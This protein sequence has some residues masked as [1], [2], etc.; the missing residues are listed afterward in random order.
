V[1]DPSLI[2]L[3]SP[4]L[5]AGQEEAS[6]V[7][8]QLNIGALDADEPAVVTAVR[9]QSARTLET[10]RID[11]GLV[12]EHANGEL[13]IT[14]GGYG[15]RQLF[16]LVQNGADE[17]ANEPGGRLAVVL[18]DDTLYCANEGTPVTVEGANTILRMSVSRKRG[19]QIGRFG[20]GVKSVLSVTDQPQFFSR[21][22]SFGFDRSWSAR[23][24]ADAVGERLPAGTDTPVLRMARPLD[25][26]VE[27]D[28]DSV[29]RELLE[30]ATT[31]VKLPLLPGAADRLGHDISGFRHRDG[32]VVE[33]FPSGFQLFSSH[34]GEVLLEDR[35]QRPVFRRKL[36]VKVSGDKRT[37]R[38]V[39]TGKKESVEE[40]SV[41]TVAHEPTAKARESA[42]ELHDRAIIDVS[43]AV[44][45]Y[46]EKDGLLTVAAG[47]GAFWSFFPTKYPVSLTGYLNA[48]WKTNEDRQNLLDGSPLNRE[49]LQVAARLVVTSLPKLA[50]RQDPAAYLPLLPGRVKEALNWAEAH[51]IDVLWD[52][53]AQLPSLPDQDGV[54]RAPRD[55]RI[56]PDK[57]QP[58]WLRMWSE[59]PKRPR[60]WVHPSVEATPLRHGKMGHILGAANKSSESVR[61]WLEALVADGTPEA[62]C[63]AIRILAAMVE[64][65]GDAATLQ[66][67]RAAR[68]VLTEGHGLVAPVAGK[69]FH[70]TGADE[71]RDD[72]V[73][74]HPAIADRMEMQR[75]LHTIGIR[76]ADAH[77]RFQGVLDQGFD[78]YTPALWTQFWTLLRS[79]GGN[80][81]VDRI[82]A[83]Y[84]DA[85][86]AL[87]VR[88]KDGRFRP[89]SHCLLPGAVVPRDGSRDASLTVDMD[90]HG[91]D[92]AIFRDLGLS[93][94][95]AV[96]SDPKQQPWFS[97]YREAMHEEYLRGLPVNAPRTSIGRMHLE[98]AAPAG[99]LDL[100][101]RL[102]E[103]GRAAFVAA[104]PDVGIVE[105]WT[106]SYGAA[107]NARVGV[108]SPLL[109][110]LRRHGM[111]STSLGIV[112]LRKAVGPQL[113]QF[114]QVL[115][116]ASDLSEEK[117]RRLHLPVT[118]EAVPADRW[119]S[120]LEQVLTSEDDAFIGRAYALL[121]R[122]GFEFPEDVLTRCRVGKRWDSRADAEIAV[123][124]SRSDFDEL[125]REE[126][127]ALLVADKSDLPTA[128]E[129]IE[130]W[131]MSKVADV[132]SKQVRKV[133]AHPATL[134]VDEF[135][136]L[137]RRLG[138]SIENRRVQRCSDLDQEIRTPHA[139]DLRPLKS[140]RTGSTL[141]VLDTL[142]PIEV[143]AAADKE[144]AWNLGAQ[145]CRNILETMEREQ[146]S[147]AIQDRIAEIAGTESVIDKIAL[148]I[149]P[150]EL[151]RGL[152]PGLYDSEVEERGGQ[153]PDA[154]R[155]AELAF[156]A[157]GE[158]ILRE[159]AKALAFA[160]PGLAPSS[161]NGDVKALK[162]VTD[163]GFP[164]SFAGARVPP[165]QSRFTVDGPSEFP[166]LHDYQE[167]LAQALLE[168][169]DSPNPQRGML[170]MPTGAG[171]TRV[172]SE[173]VIRWIRE[174]K[175]L[176]GPVLW[177][178]DR[179]ELCEQAVQSWRFVWG[180]VG[181]EVPLVISRLWSSNEA[182]P[183]TGQPHLVVATDAKLQSVLGRDDYA[184]LREAALVIVDEAHLA[185]SPRYGEI[186][187][188]LGVNPPSTA[189]HLIGLTATPYRNDTDLTLRLV[190][191]FGKRLDTEVFGGDQN[192]AIRQ[193]QALGVLTRVTHRQLDGAD[194]KLSLEEVAS[195]RMFGVL[196]KR[197][198]QR[199]A[200]DR[201][202]N[203]RILDEI[204]N[205]PADWPI[206]VFATSV[207]HA[208]FLAAKLN[209]R[210]VK[211]VS[212]DSATPMSDRRKRIDD[213]RRGR[214][215]VLTNYGV[216][217]QGF[218]APATRAVFV[219]RPTYSPNV[220]QQMIGRGLRG[221]KNN[222]TEKCLIVNVK[223]NV[224]NFQ[225][226]LAFTKFDYLWNGER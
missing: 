144:F 218:D 90:F 204:E 117:A 28:E 190:H 130:T 23:E 72:M 151:L 56:H 86:A 206:L 45:A 213:F 55:L 162:F 188:H 142:T 141:L 75:H 167:R 107:V 50:P 125:V 47:R 1:P 183:V 89:M 113:K 67:A 205:L 81:Q 40:W 5:R 165:L 208:K 22:G 147:R 155:I 194:I 85:R 226:E 66:S 13:R 46:T 158:S 173:A 179:E 39:G 214:V 10:Y 51:F 105:N 163:L 127:P 97:E 9:E 77:G 121:F 164:D 116:V 29:L 221:P 123:A 176:P 156:N 135:P 32:R 80:A 111:V 20:V 143:L 149:G 34:V 58:E 134:L 57:L 186:F 223:D 175:E 16:E 224:V 62:S 182:T 37:I 100:L 53:A 68:I 119:N 2:T 154:H 152:P 153:E 196:P 33:P 118:P 200:E 181:A 31:V 174:R 78:N 4:A 187:E 36:T 159:H 189:R 92:A 83:R 101:P 106:R 95:P 84:P 178:A 24:I 219:A 49:L 104:I 25:Q 215:Q 18:T 112:P 201:D 199:L 98:G 99:P 42:G 114:S 220:Y 139:V 203:Q 60:N 180:K 138:K 70:R 93:D 12:Q 192:E 140:A 7:N 198:E 87:H 64:H 54:L 211:A 124:T 82:R 21:T 128:A 122:I 169:L 65:N 79:A 38:E 177:I 222:G 202:R 74:V 19:G 166:A 3:S 120:L 11:P 172:T 209:D 161:F 185:T 129:M 59:Y 137:R 52:T 6:F 217:A 197:A 225:G 63:H 145:G 76:V 115:A 193:L 41:F 191:R 91:P 126:L 136:P 212:I 216:L 102:S 184:W 210:G 88:A 94:R 133:G 131:G 43:W 132:I 96:S 17:V 146:K 14:Q 160:F 103:A 48:A 73:Y 207:A 171:K 170:S 168:L 71:L 8:E 195:S 157:H 15:E 26:E 150:E 110:M 61:D 35:R 148:L 69:V 30:W 27:A 109:W 108:I 44:P